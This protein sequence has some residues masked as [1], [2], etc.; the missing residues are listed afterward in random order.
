MQITLSKSLSAI[1]LA[2]GITLPALADG[3]QSWDGTLYR[4]G[5]HFGTTNS[6]V[7]LETAANPVSTASPRERATAPKPT[8]G[9]NYDNTLYRNGG[10]FGDRNSDIALETATSK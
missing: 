7:A 3:S 5:G 10:H 2:M 1:S 9:S 6:D 4:N 8:V